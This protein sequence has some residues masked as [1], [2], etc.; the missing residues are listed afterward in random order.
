MSPLLRDFIDI[1]ESVHK[2]DFV[3][4]LASG[5]ANSHDTIADYVVTEQLALAYDNALAF[6]ASAVRESTSKAAYLDGSFGSGKSHFM[7]VLHLLLQGDPEAR[8]IPELAPVIAK[9]DPAIE[10]KSFDLVPF[11]LIGAE[12]MEQAIFGGY[13]EHLREIDASAPLPGIYADGPL[14]EEADQRRADLGDETFFARLNGGEGGGNADEGWGDLA[15]AWDAERYERAKAADVG[16]PDRGRL[17][18][19]IVA[20]ILP[21]FREAMRGNPTGYVD[22]DTGLAE[23][24]RHAH[25]RGSDALILFLDE[26]I[27]WLGSRI[28]DP[29]FVAREGQKLIKLIEFTTPRP[30]PVISFVARQRDLREFVGDQ[31]PGV[32]K[33]SFAD[34]LRHWNDRFH[35]V[36]LD[37][38]NL[39]KIAERRLLRPRDESARQAIDSAFRETDRARP[40]VLDVLMTEDGDR[41]EFRATYPFSPA[42]MKALVAASSALQRERTALRVMLQL[43]VDRRDELELGDL[44]SVGELFDVL[45]Q[46]DEPFAEEMKRHFEHAKEVY[47]DQF[48]PLLAAES[49]DGG[50]PSPADERLV[51]TL[52]LAA[53]VPQAAPLRKLD[54]AKLTALNHGSIASPIPGQERAIV[55]GKLRKWSAQ[56]GALKLG[57]D[58]QN[59]SVEVRLT[60]VDVDSII[61]RADSVDSAGERRRLVKDLVLGELGIAVDTQLFSEHRVL[62][63]G[64]R[65]TVDVAF[66]NVRDTQDLPDDSLAATDD[67]WR[68]VVDYPFD[69]GHTPNEDLERLALWRQEHGASRTV[70][71]IPAFFSQG[72]QRDLKRLVI[73]RHVLADQRLDQYADHLSPQDRQQARGI[74]GDMRSALEQRVKAAIRQAYGVERALPDTIDGSHGVEERLQSLWSGFSPQVPIGAQLSDALGGL[75]EQ[76]LANQFPGHP[77]FETEV[78]ARELRIV[79]EEV[80]RAADSPDGRVEVPSDRRKVM[81]QVAT[82]LQLGVQHEAPFVLGTYWKDHLD[83]AI[84]RAVQGDAATIKVRDLRQWVEEPHALGLPREVQS[85]VVLAYAAQTSRSFRL[86]GGPVQPTVEQLDDEFE[87]VTID[88]PSEHAW[89]IAGERAAGVFGLAAVNPARNAASFERLVAELREHGAALLPA[90]EQLVPLL[91]GRL[92][93]FDVDPAQATRLSTAVDARDLVAGLDS[94][95]EGVTLIERFAGAALPGGVETVGKSLSSASEVVAALENPHWQM[96]SVVVE[97]AHDGDSAH[98]RIVDELVQV[99]VRDEFAA[100]VAAAVERAASA[101]IELLRATAPPP[102]VESAPIAVDGSAGGE[103][104]EARAL[105]LT[106]ARSKLDDLERAGGALSI[107]LTWTIAT[108]RDEA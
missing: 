7:A 45:A 85:L 25:D 79:L 46:G 103:R 23:L 41:E 96:L 47:R 65:R 62:W 12:S 13:V 17:G 10:A 55:L 52:L 31:I 56:I 82:P 104:G 95:V 91:E 69:P 106:A 27:L 35:L 58:L 98:Q 34:A 97:R 86:H 16:D 78:K 14:F 11:H 43:L 18:G 21:G 33:L 54:V 2:G 75:V 60:G 59:P 93:Q 19:A 102:A 87:L 42:F 6:I 57:E 3:M 83:K 63:R 39:P 9:Y 88:L 15:V 5:V 50:D 105:D 99:L 30:I 29:A 101:G 61:A 67:R 81:R 71:W 100:P 24:A 22:L 80:Q 53:L 73:V 48:Q 44:V 94:G 70:C 72:M 49:A 28:A 36:S 4:S 84:A 64:T 74:L 92:K 90:A 26:L 77:H 108:E 38:R 1:P 68:I 66:G 76:M 8:A 107:D 20:T 32:E 37:D 51:K 40:E 89:R